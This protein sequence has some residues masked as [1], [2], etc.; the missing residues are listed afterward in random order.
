MAYRWRYNCQIYV[1]LC[2]FPVCYDCVE[3]LVYIKKI[4]ER[5]GK[6]DATTHK[7][8]QIKRI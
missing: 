2:V 3:E 5:D 8:T 4:R 7:H 1:C 6:N